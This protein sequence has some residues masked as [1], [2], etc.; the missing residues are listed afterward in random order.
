MANAKAWYNSPEYQKVLPLRTNNTI[1][2]LILVDGVRPDF[3]TAGY[4][5]QIRAAIAAA[6]DSGS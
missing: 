1:N 2:D 5:Q 3:T 6:A 4:A